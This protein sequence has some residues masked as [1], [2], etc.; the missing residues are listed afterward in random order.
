MEMIMAMAIG[1]LAASGTW[2][3][4]RPRTFQVIMVARHQHDLCMRQ[5]GK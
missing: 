1:I 5:S 4:L 3:I 2:L